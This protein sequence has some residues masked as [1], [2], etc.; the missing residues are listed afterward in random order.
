MISYD[1]DTLRLFG[2]PLFTLMVGILF[3]A[4]LAGLTFGLFRWQR[5]AGKVAAIASGFILLL[6]AL[7][8]ALVLVTVGSGS[9]G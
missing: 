6:F 4:A 3:L 8:I 1:H 2:V 9:M 5:L 7:A